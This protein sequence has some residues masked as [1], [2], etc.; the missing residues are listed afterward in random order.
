MKIYN[1]WDFPGAPV[2][3]TALPEQGAG[4]QPLVRELDATCC[5]GELTSL[6]Q[7]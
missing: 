4:V 2:A 3:N 7:N 6:S 5:N 1:F